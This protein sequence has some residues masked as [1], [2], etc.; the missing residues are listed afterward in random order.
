MNMIKF[1]SLNL[2]VLISSSL[3]FAF[4][5]VSNRCLL[6]GT[7]KSQIDRDMHTIFGGDT[8]TFVREV[9]NSSESRGVTSCVELPESPTNE[10]LE[11]IFEINRVTQKADQ[12]P[13]SYLGVTINGRMFEAGIYFEPNIYKYQTP[14]KTPK[15]QDRNARYFPPGYRLFTAGFFKKKIQYY[16]GTTF[17]PGDRVCLSLYIHPTTKNLIYKVMKGVS[18]RSGIPVRNDIVITE[19]TVPKNIKQIQFK[20][21][22]GLALRQQEMDLHPGKNGGM[23]TARYDRMLKEKVYA[24][25]K[26]TSPFL[27]DKK[28][29]ATQIQDK[30]YLLAPSKGTGCSMT[31]IWPRTGF[32]L[33]NVTS[34]ELLIEMIPQSAPYYRPVRIAPPVATVTVEE[35]QTESESASPAPVVEN[36]DFKDVPAQ[37]VED[38]VGGDKN[39]VSSPEEHFSEENS[40][41]EENQK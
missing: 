10:Q 18:T 6:I 33:T 32:K 27:L 1:F 41:E 25:M 40:Q 19:Y 29:R 14:P 35:E 36:Q 4:P 20:R 3:V 13:Y 38:S 30:D 21:V 7:Y 16:R 9:F 5:Q 17:K 2:A 8:G 39:S 12:A 37:T 22:T 23:S 31:T 28:Y 34:K 15:R 11:N 26:W 24:V